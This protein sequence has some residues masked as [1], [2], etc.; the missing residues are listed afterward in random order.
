MQIL[1]HLTFVLEHSRQLL[2]FRIQVVQ[3]ILRRHVALNPSNNGC[4]DET[5]LL[6]D[7]RARDGVDDDILA[8]E[9]FDELVDWVVVRYCDR[10]YGSRETAV[11]LGGMA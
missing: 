2:R 11:G 5:V 8:S 4:V 1:L 6:L 7:I 9:R 10:A 3:S